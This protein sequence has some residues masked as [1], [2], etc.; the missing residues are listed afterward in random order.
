MVKVVLSQS[1][2]ASDETE[3]SHGEAPML[4]KVMSK[5]QMFLKWK[6]WTCISNSVSESARFYNKACQS[7]A[8]AALLQLRLFLNQRSVNHS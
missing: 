1:T 6:S 2:E 3:K 5:N 4:P 7:K 8:A